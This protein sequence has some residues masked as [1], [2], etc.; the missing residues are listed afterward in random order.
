MGDVTTPTQDALSALKSPYDTDIEKPYTVIRNGINLSEIISYL[1][2]LSLFVVIITTNQSVFDD[3][4]GNTQLANASVVKNNNVVIQ[5]L[6]GSGILLC[7]IRICWANVFI[8]NTLASHIMELV[9]GLLVWVLFITLLILT[10]RTKEELNNPA[11]SQIDPVVRNAKKHIHTQHILS[12][13]GIGLSS[14]Y[15][16]YNIYVLIV[17]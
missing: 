2:M 7:L 6:C 12:I 15:T 16:V 9:F 17:S 4:S 5:A 10:L 8:K 1:I 14:L 11:L 13:I 3:L